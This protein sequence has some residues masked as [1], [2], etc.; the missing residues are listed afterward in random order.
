M[1]R[2]VAAIMHTDRCDLEPVT[3]PLSL[4][5][6]ERCILIDLLHLIIVSRAPS[7]CCYL[8]FAQRYLA[9]EILR[10]NL[11]LSLTCTHQCTAVTTLSPRKRERH[12]MNDLTPDV[13]FC[14]CTQD[15][16]RSMTAMP[17]DEL[18]QLKRLVWRPQLGSQQYE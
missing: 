7:D 9:T 12:T 8:R 14:F 3:N 15:A 4:L 11:G 18:V 10:S 13:M 1:H 2:F 17:S 6:Y 16:R 5:K